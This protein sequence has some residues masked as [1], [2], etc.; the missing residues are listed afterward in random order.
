M[1]RNV[2]KNVYIYTCITLLYSRNYHNTVTQLYFNKI[3]IVRKQTK[4][5]MDNIFA[6]MYFSKEHI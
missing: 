6:D 2:K 1:E 3:Y 4:I 5:K